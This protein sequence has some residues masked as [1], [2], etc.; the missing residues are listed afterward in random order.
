MI[1]MRH[2]QAEPGE[3]D[4]Q[5]PL[6]AQGRKDAYNMALFLHSAGC[7]PLEIHASPLRRAQETQKILWEYITANLRNPP[8]F[9]NVQEPCAM[10]TEDSLRPGFGVETSLRLL[11]KQNLSSKYFSMWVLHAPDIAFV[12]AYLTAMPA[13]N[14]YFSPGSALALNLNPAHS[15]GGQA[16]QIWHN[17]PAALRAL[18]AEK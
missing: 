7:F 1:L 15:K 2:A 4:F 13:G 17:Q 10:Y 12:A 3:D 6:S 9:N 8:E 18:F 14:F 16:M 11:E 5:R